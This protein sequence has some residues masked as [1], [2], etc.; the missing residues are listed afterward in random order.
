MRSYCHGPGP[1]VPQD[2]SPITIALLAAGLLSP[3][4]FAQVEK[5]GDL[6]VDVDATKL[7]TGA[8]TS[9]PNGG[10]L[11]G[12]FVP[13]GDAVSST[14]P[15]VTQV[16]G[17]KGIS[18][19]GTD[20]LQLADAASGGT[21]ITAPD[22][23]VGLDAT[24]SIEAWV[25]NPAV[26]SEETILSWGNRGGP[27]GSNMSFNYGSNY[28]YGAI[29]HWGTPDI[30]W[31]N[32]GGSPPANK[33]HH[34]VATY[35][36][37]ITRVYADGVL[38]NLEYLGPGAIDIHTGT[39]I[40]LAAQ[41]EGDGVTVTGAL[42]GSMTI[43]RVRIHDGVLTGA[44]IAS[45]YNLE[46]AD[47]IDPAIPP[48]VL[49]EPLTKG[50][51]HRYSF[52]ETAS[53]N[54]TGATIKD[55]VGTADG[56]VQ[57]DGAEFTGTSLRLAGGGSAT[58]AYA[59]LPNGLVS[60][61]GVANGGTGEWS[62][63]TWMKPTGSRTWSR[64]FDFGSTVSDDGTG[65]VVGPG[66]GGTG[67]DYLEYSAQI[68]DDVNSRRLELRNEDPG[69]GGVF[70]RDVSTRTFN[71]QVQVLVTWKE[72]TGRITL[73]ENGNSIGTLDVPT[74]M[75][76]LNDVNVWLGR[77]NWSGDQNTQGEFDEARFY[78]YVLTP[79]QALGNAISGP[80]LV[81]D[82]AVAV[83]IVDQP[84]SLTLPDTYKATFTVGASGSAPIAYR[85]F[86]NN[87]VI[88]G[89]TQSSYSIPAVVADDN[90]ASFTVEVSN[91]VNGQPVKVVSN[92]AVLS[93]V[94]DPVTLKHRYSFSETSATTTVDSVSGANGEVLGSASLSGGRLTLDGADNS[95]VNL[96]NGIVTALGNNGTIEMWL[97]YDGGPVWSRA[98]DFGTKDDG[99]D[100]VGNGID[101]LFFTPRNGDGIPRFYANFPNQGDTTVLNL[102]TSMLPGQEYYIAITYSF[103]GN[104]ARMY[105]DGA[106]VATGG[107]LF[108]LS[109]MN[110]TDN[111]IWLGRSQFPADAFYAG[112]F[113]EL[114][115]SQG[116]LTPAQV[117]AS[118]AAGPDSL[119]S[120]TP[121]ALTAVL[122]GTSLT[123]TWPA[124]AIGYV[125]EGVSLLNSPDWTDLGNGLPIVDGK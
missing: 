105:L 6:L 100:G 67:L 41:L 94:G 1:R 33:W 88:D 15:A 72:S 26:D 64:F 73:Y 36:G 91:S 13:T 123:V 108:P 47:F 75:S 30:G 78:D 11:G 57:G 56:T 76:D 9:V 46:K 87:Q 113:N 124:S 22:G 31:T 65:E 112:K 109:A 99:E 62:F 34:L 48:I 97:S 117:T 98:F 115:I 93:V 14:T 89:A 27:E 51:I 43:A 20:F 7:A 19:D 32:E 122:D 44:Q 63:E 77:S 61:H 24:S 120:A 4:A 85:W 5:A 35:D 10:T 21:I 80:D 104:T 68:G 66:G 55:S 16:G 110:G 84:D 23:I 60:S 50:P 125:L 12:F 82:K 103:S 70:T 39:A 121:P 17:T 81:N 79:G 118:F 29:G 86:R 92:P 116:A 69:G 37:T 2:V 49:P 59:D 58:S 40:S 101:Y 53:A 102:P 111:N 45:N 38:S 96:P 8:F 25:L 54:A 107:A 3:A 95:Y 52:S 106:L 74:Q 18:F 119:P 90:N 42:R 83:T 28:A 114:R 71:T